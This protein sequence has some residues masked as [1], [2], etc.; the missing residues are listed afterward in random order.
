MTQN[1]RFLAFW[2][3]FQKMPKNDDFWPK[4]V[5]LA[6]I[7]KMSKK[8]SK[9]GYKNRPKIRT[10]K[11]VQKS[12]QK[13]VQKPTPKMDPK[14]CPKIGPKS[15]QN[16]PPLRFGHFS[17]FGEKGLKNENHVFWPPLFLASSLPWQILTPK[18]T[19]FYVKSKAPPLLFFRTPNFGSGSY[20]G[21]NRTFK[22]STF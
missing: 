3:K 16:R 10:P 20:P 17:D 11:K 8:W 21:K 13:W 9:T 5:K 1:R 14:K 22:K 2:P 12:V 7:Q 19:P 18:N 4:I 15:V 6:K